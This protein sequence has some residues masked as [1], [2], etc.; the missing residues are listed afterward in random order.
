MQT[1]T[2]YQRLTGLL[3]MFSALLALGSMVIGAF[4]VE[5]NFDAFSDPTILLNYSSHYEAGKWSMLLDMLGYYLLLLPVIFYL[6]ERLMAKT[7]WADVFTFCGLAYVLVGAIGAA[8][9][10]SVWPQQM[11]RYLVADP[12]GRAVLQSGLENVSW[13]VYGGMWNILEVL[14]CGVWWLGL[15]F[16]LKK[17]FRAL[18]IVTILLGGATLADGAGNMAGLK[19]VAETGLNLYLVLA[20]VWPAWIGWLIYKKRL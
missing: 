17:D 19:S 9:L 4:A 8:I 14:L 6:H 3:T 5:F 12:A 11:Q 1:T 10:A 20:I 2:S 18:G 7:P 15:G 13:I 16:V